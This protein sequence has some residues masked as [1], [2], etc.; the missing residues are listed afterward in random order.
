[1][2]HIA[3]SAAAVVLALSVFGAVAQ[4]A[5]RPEVGKPLQAAQEMLKAGRYKDALAKVR[6]AEAVGNRSTYET[7]ILDRMRASA[8]ASAGDNELA[9]RAFE[10]AIASGRPN[11][12]ERLQLIE[13]LASS[14]YRGKDYAR[15]AEWAS[16][17]LKEGGAA[18][19]VR[20]LMV[21]ALFLAGNY[22]GVIGAVTPWVKSGE[23][24]DEH[25]LQLLA[26]SYAKVGDTAGYMTSLEALLR[27]AP[28]QDYWADLLSRLPGKPGFSE[29]LALDVYRLRSATG[30]LT[31]AAQFVE[32]A[33][34]ALQAGLPAEAKKVV[35]AGFTAG[36]LGVGADEN[37]HR[38]LREMAGKQ[39]AEDQKTLATFDAGTRASPEAWANTG[40]ALVSVGRF[41]KGLDLMTQALQKVDQG[42]KALKRPEDLRL[43][44]GLAHLAAGNASKAAETLRAVKGG[45]GAADLAR[46]WLLK[47]AHP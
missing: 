41:E 6:E 4:D 37:R 26:N 21:N 24:A 45:D 44:L 31:D 7:Y 20:E 2:K 30:T 33:Q 16:K 22:A 39:A 19:Q 35:D 32:M 18:A 25:T 29:R 23:A 8:A 46:L 3:R 17:Y 15:A 11:A 1:M 14:A 28:K 38:R 34:L 12:A 36:A 42:D 40:G 43:H 10:S 27:Q 5:L 47:L 9:A 13:A